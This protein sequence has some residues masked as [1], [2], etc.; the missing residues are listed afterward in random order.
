MRNRTLLPLSLA[1]GLA[2]S[3]VT[4]AADPFTWSAAFRARTEVVDQDA[5]ASRAVA[6][7][8]RLRLGLKWTLGPSASAFLE[9]EAVQALND[10]FNSGAN[11]ETAFPAIADASAREINS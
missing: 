10:H 5:F 11:G 9:G 2:L 6:H 1:I 4:R 3:P 8:A 7:T